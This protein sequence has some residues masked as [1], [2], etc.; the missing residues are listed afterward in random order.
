MPTPSTSTGK[1]SPTTSCTWRAVY[2]RI[3][4]LRDEGKKY[5]DVE[6]IGASRDFQASPISRAA[7]SIATAPSSPLPAN[8]TKSCWSRRRP[9]NTR[10]RSSRLPDVET[11]SILEYRYKLRYDDNR[12]SLRSGTSSSLSSF[13]RPTSTSFPPNRRSS[14]TSTRAMSPAA[15]LQPAPAQR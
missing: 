11:G 7:P 5:A 15:R 4:I 2:V 13:A 12:S 3:K 14:P 10:P 8:P 1:M 6:L 9:G